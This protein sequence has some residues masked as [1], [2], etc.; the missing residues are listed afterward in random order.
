MRLSAV[1]AMKRIA[2]EEGFKLKDVK[3]NDFQNIDESSID[4]DAP[5]E[6]SDEFSAQLDIWANL[7]ISYD[8]TPPDSYRVLNS[9]I[10]DWVDDNESA[11]KKEINPELVKFLKKK[12]PNLDVSDLNEDFD[13]YIWEDQ[14]D[15]MP[16]IDEEDKT[17]NFTLELVLEID[18]QEESNASE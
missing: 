13:D 17:I 2:S 8:G 3:F 16:D 14:V 18:E 7:T 4:V 12:Y 11:L 9:I 10:M 1:Q 6:E 15:Y 5:G